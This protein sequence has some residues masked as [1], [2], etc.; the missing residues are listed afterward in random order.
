MCASTTTCWSSKCLHPLH[1]TF[2]CLF[3]SFPFPS[4]IIPLFPPPFHSLGE[5]LAI[6]ILALY[7]EHSLIAS[8]LPTA[9]RASQHGALA[10]CL[11][12]HCSV[13]IHCK[14]KKKKRNGESDWERET[15]TQKHK[16][17]ARENIYKRLSKLPEASR[18]IIC[19]LSL[20]L[21]LSFLFFS[22]PETINGVLNQTS[23][24]LF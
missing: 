19:F 5:L 2:L 1:N 24:V 17:R 22:Q 20:S 10:V 8:V 3:L 15:H 12:C 18:L 7:C 9:G 16:E 23:L 11:I 4:C 14:R 13:D 6:W 21:P